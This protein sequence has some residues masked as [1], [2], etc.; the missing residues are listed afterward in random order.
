[1]QTNNELSE[2]AGID[3]TLQLPRTALL[4]IIAAKEVWAPYNDKSKGLRIALLSANTVGGMDITEQNYA[5]L[6]NDASFNPRMLQYHEC[7]SITNLTAKYLGLDVFTAT[8]STACSS[9]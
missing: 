5:K 3:A 7:G 9:S 1:K 6:K 4:S 8:I 2:R